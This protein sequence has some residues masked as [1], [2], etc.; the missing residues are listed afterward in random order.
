MEKYEEIDKNG[1]QVVYVDLKPYFLRVIKGWKTILLWALCGM[2]LGIIIGLSKPKT[3]TS[4]AV[5]APEIA[6]RNTLGSNSSLSTLASLAGINA[7][8][9]AMTDAMHPD[10]YP[11]IIASTDFRIGLFDLPVEFTR[12]GQKISTDLYDYVANYTKTPWYSYVV[13]L[14]RICVEAAKGIFAKKD[15]DAEFDYSEGHT[16]MDSLR[17]TRQQERVVKALARS[18]K[19]AVERRTYV[20]S[21]QVT[22]Q[23]RM[24]AAQVANAVLDHLQQFV[25]K[26]RTEKAQNNVEY[27]EKIYQETH[28]EYMAAQRSYAYYSDSHQGS[29]SR[30]SQVE[31]QRLQNEANL[32]FQMYNTTAQNLLTARA[33]VQE[34]APVLVVLQQ[35]KAPINGKPSKVS[36]AIL[37]FFI[38]AFA[39]ALWALTR[40]ERTSAK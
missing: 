40:R 18:I 35:A 30:I 2:L 34:E 31:Q 25:V 24:V 14:P 15:A 21:V 36:L 7:N 38:G 9:L 19:A 16:Q 37:F 13:A 12:S 22:M 26:Y 17:L 6:T 10:L 1:E 28:D 32:K 4:T 39:G 5:V 27:F 3:F 20:L 23:D 11:M 8:S 33:R 29:L